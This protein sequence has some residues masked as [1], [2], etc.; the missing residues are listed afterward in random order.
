M[1]YVLIGSQDWFDEFD[2]YFFEIL[3]EDQYKKY[4]FLQQTL[5]HFYGN[6]WFGTNEGWE[7]FDF[8]D[9]KVT[10]ATDEELEILNKFKVV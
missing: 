7:D 5:K 2:L 8:L 4:T 3:T 1:K 9:F 6:Y 10:Q